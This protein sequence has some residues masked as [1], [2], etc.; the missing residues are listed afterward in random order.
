M[1]E[2]KELLAYCGGYCGDCLGYTGVLADTADS[3]KVVVDTHKVNQTIQCV[4]PEQGEKYWEFYEMLTFMTHLRCPK[5][6]RERKGEE[7]FCHI[8]KCC[9]KKGFFAC[10]ECDE[11]ETCNLLKSKFNGLH[12]E[13][14]MRNLKDIKEMGLEE[15]LSKGKRH[16][17]WDEAGDR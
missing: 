14:N 12:Y 2:R 6:C 16:C 13:S 17:Y 15:W 9:R 3:L 7:V 1:M 8:A 11:L 10:Y 4:F 5:I